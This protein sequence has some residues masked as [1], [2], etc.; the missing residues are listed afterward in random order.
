MPEKKKLT[1]STRPDKPV[2][3]LPKAKSVGKARTSSKPNI[4]VNAQTDK[5]DRPRRKGLARDQKHNKPDAKKPASTNLLSRKIT[6]NILVAV[7]AIF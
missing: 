5:N 1:T 2:L 7:D 6:Y 3:R 4:K